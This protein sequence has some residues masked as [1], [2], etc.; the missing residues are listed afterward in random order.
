MNIH[1]HKDLSSDN[2]RNT[3]PKREYYMY[4]AQEHGGNKMNVE[5]AYIKSTEDERVAEIARKRLNG[6][7]KDICLN[8][9]IGELD[10]YNV[11]LAN[12]MKRKIAISSPKKGWITVIE[13]KEINDY[14]LLL[15][16]SKDLQTE[17]LAIMQ[18]DAAGAWGFVEILEGEVVKNYFSYDDDEIEDLLSRKLEEKEIMESIHM[19]REVVKERGKGWEIVQT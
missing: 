13:S 3:F 5:Q 14:T 7:I 2:N 16:I 15:Q 10:S 17:V 8:D 11:F 1:L 4:L 12:D 6:E 19:F 9:Q 18:S